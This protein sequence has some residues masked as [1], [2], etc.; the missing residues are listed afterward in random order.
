MKK[1]NLSAVG[2]A[3]LR[4]L[5]TAGHIT[6]IVSCLFVGFSA[7]EIYRAYKKGIESSELPQV[8]EIAVTSVAI[9]DRGELMIID[10]HSGKY[11]LFSDSVGQAIFNQY[12]SKIYLKKQSG[13]P[14]E[15]KP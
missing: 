12:A 2:G 11:M 1:I 9:N 4:V 15:T 8:Q 7:G 13:A 10:R 5:R 14:A 6:V 3:I